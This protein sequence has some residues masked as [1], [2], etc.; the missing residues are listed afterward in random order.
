MWK[1]R[2][3]HF[4][5]A[6][7]LFLKTGSGGGGGEVCFVFHFHKTRFQIK[8]VAPSLVLKVRVVGARK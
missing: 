1:W 2:I 8:D 5:V 3:S 4:Q 7:H 6:P